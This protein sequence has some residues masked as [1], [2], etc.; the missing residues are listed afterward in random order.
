MKVMYSRYLLPV[1]AILLAQPVRAQQKKAAVSKAKTAVS[2]KKVTAQQAKRI[3][4]AQLAREGKTG[5]RR[6]YKRNDIEKILHTEQEGWAGTAENERAE[7]AAAPA[8]GPEVKQV[9]VKK[10]PATIVKTTAREPKFIEGI[11]LERNK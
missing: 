5:T 4:E 8:P 11:V 1:L 10:E 7:G 9:P 2:A 3:N 6:A